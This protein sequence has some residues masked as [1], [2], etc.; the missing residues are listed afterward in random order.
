MSRPALTPQQPCP[1]WQSLLEEVSDLYQRS[2]GLE[3]SPVLSTEPVVALFCAVSALQ[4]AGTGLTAPPL[5]R[6]ALT[7][8]KNSED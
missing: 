2:L 5:A 4:T 8:C 1:V 3:R 7:S 6:A